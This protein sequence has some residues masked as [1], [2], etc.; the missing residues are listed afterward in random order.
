ML[1]CG[2]RLPQGL[3][4]ELWCQPPAGVRCWDSLVHGARG[5]GSG[6]CAHK[7]YHLKIYNFGHRKEEEWVY[8]TMVIFVSRDP[9]TNLPPPALMNLNA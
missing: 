7:Y 9:P 8:S 2:V 6:V 5:G 3:E 4:M 1:G